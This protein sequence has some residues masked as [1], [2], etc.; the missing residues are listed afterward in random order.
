M[1]LPTKLTRSHLC[2]KT[3]RLGAFTAAPLID[4]KMETTLMSI[5]PKSIN[6]AS[7]DRKEDWWGDGEMTQRT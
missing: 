1:L 6:G 2:D 3:R 5:T 7:F 4:Q